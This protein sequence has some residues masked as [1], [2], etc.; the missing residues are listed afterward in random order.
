MAAGAAPTEVDPYIAPVTG[1]WE[2]MPQLDHLKTLGLH[3]QRMRLTGR[4]VLTG[5][6][7][8]GS[9]S[10]KGGT[11]APSRPVTCSIPLVACVHETVQARSGACCAGKWRCQ[12]EP[13]DATQRAAITLTLKLQGLGAVQVPLMAKV[14]VSLC[15]PIKD[16]YK[17]CEIVVPLLIH[18][19]ISCV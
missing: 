10:T 17:H 18:V 16:F 9:Q 8:L 1:Q 6:C 4:P 14:P 11:F 19:T 2:G 12:A 5:P 3:F 13:V 15:Q 7:N